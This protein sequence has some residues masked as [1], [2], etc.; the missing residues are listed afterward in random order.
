[1]PVY[2]VID[3]NQHL[4]VSDA[5][6]LEVYIDVIID[7]LNGLVCIDVLIDHNTRL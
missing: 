5:Q 7:V 3:M 2:G 6:S 4:F 1:L